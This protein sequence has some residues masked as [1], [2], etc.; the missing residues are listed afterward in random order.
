[1]LQSN[2]LKE[3]LAQPAASDDGIKVGTEAMVTQ[4]ARGYKEL[5]ELLSRETSTGQKRIELLRRTRSSFAS[6]GHTCLLGKELLSTVDQEIK[7]LSMNLPQNTLR[8]LRNRSR[9]LLLRIARNTL[10]NI[11]NKK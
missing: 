11:K 8:H 7:L 1:M 3:K 5:Y 2:F 4:L 10:T 9:S 6:L